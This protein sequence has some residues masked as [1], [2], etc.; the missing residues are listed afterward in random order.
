MTARKVPRLSLKYRIDATVP[1]PASLNDHKPAHTQ[2]TLT[3]VEIELLKDWIRQGA[4]WQQHWSFTS[5]VRAALPRVKNS[6]WPRNAI[7]Y[8]VLAKLEQEGLHPSP[9]AARR[10]TPATAARR[11]S[12]SSTSRARSSSTVPTICSSSTAE[13][14]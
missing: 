1:A 12:P 2:R 13:T 10:A 14:T 7:D 3:G 11:S 8:F 9:E 6:A 5:P 4:V